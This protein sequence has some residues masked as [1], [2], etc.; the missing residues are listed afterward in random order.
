MKKIAL[1]ILIILAAVSC[2]EKYEYDQT[3]GLLSEYNVLSNG[4]GSTQVAVFSNTS[5]TVE[6]DREVSWASIDRF[7]GIKSGYL[8]FD[9]DVNYG[10]SRRV[11]LIFKAGDKT[12]TLNMYQQAFLSDS[13]CEMTLD[14]TSLDIPAAGA[15]LDIPFTTNLVYNLDEM[16][17]TL[18]Y[19]EGQEPAAPW[20][21]LKSVEKDK[22]SIEIAPNTTGADRTA[23]MKISHTDAGAYDST[24]G[25]TIH[26][27]TV[28]V[29]Q[30]K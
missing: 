21:T 17:L 8:V 5:W 7:N 4:G 6:M 29:V 11:I 12:L 16:F 14:A 2:R 15:S 25:D 18:T 1:Y 30:P 28:T 24:E 19:P 3:L 20:I 27:N 9:Y 13:N 22:V 23:N 26:S 10:R